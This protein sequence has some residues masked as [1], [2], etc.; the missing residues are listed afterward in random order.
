MKSYKPLSVGQAPWDAA[1]GRCCR[2][3]TDQYQRILSFGHAAR[4]APPRRSAVCDRPLDHVALLQPGVVRGAA[5]LYPLDHRAP[6]LSGPAVA[7]AHRG[8][9]TQPDSPAR[10]RGLRPGFIPGLV[11]LPWL[12]VTG[13]VRL[14]VTPTSD[15]WLC[16]DSGL[17][18]NLQSAGVVTSL[19]V[20]LGDDVPDFQSLWRRA[21]LVRPVTTV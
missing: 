15:E 17:H 11:R 16:P 1:R 13:V 5:R 7:G 18:H 2:R 21:K 4:A 8:D 20:D 10:F 9:V 3:W 19:A 6:R 12:R 14:A